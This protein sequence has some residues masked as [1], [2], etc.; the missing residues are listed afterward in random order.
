MNAREAYEKALW[1]ELPEKLRKEIEKC[2]EH[3]YTET[4]FFRSYY[5]DFFEKKNL[6]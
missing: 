4:Y 5:P 1:N 3:G 6:I 2:V